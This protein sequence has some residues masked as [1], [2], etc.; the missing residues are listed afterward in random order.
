MIIF[1]YSTQHFQ[2]DSV[3]NNTELFNNLLAF[4]YCQDSSPQLRI[5]GLRWRNREHYHLGLKSS[6]VQLGTKII[7][8]YSLGDSES[9]RLEKEEMYIQPEEECSFCHE[10]KAVLNI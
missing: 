10:K 9:T 8:E 6:E 5:E 1:R 7:I 4:K 2:V 3:Y